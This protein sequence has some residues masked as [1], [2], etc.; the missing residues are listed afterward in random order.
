M[1]PHRERELRQAVAEAWAEYKTA[2]PEDREAAHERYRTLLEMLTAC[3]LPR[4]NEG[5]LGPGK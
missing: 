4:S 1:D 3:V 5:T 2:S